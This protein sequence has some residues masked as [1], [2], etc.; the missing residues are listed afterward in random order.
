MRSS[1]RNWGIKKKANQLLAN[2]RFLRT[3]DVR[4]LEKRSA[5][6]K[7]E[8]D[9]AYG[10]NYAYSCSINVACGMSSSASSIIAD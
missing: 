2:Y 6:F 3:R 5:L 9:L 10:G 1:W 7:L 4:D 8:K